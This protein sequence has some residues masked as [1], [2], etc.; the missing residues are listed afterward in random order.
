MTRAHRY[1]RGDTGPAVAEIRR[2]LAVLG[3]LPRPPGPARRP[4]SAQFD[5][6]TSTRAV[7]AVPAAARPHRRR[8]RRPAD[9]PRARRGALAARRPDPVLHRQPPDVRRRRRRAAAAAARP[10]LRLRPRRR[11]LRA[12]DRAAR[13]SEFQRN[14]GLRRRRHLRPGDV[15]GARPA[16]PHGRRRPPARAARARGDPAQRAGAVRQGRRH[17]PRPRRRRPRRRRRTAWTRPALV[18]DLAVAGRGPAD[19]HRRARV[20]DP[21]APTMDHATSRAAPASPTPPTPT[22]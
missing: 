17:R 2:K 15:Q 22:S 12:A 4:T 9:L 5:D 11:H 19:G 16:R 3:L 20:P 21:R 8:H 6:A 13:C 14:I 1:R 7:R 10:G 18:E